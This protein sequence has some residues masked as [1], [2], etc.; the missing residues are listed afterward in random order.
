MGLISLPDKKVA[1]SILDEAY[2]LVT[3]QVTDDDGDTKEAV[4]RV[5]LETFLTN[6]GFDVDFDEDA[7]VLYLLDKTGQRV[8]VGTTIVAGITGLSMTT[9]EDDSGNQYLIL[10]D[11]NGVEL[12]RTE[13]NA[14]GS[15]TGSAYTCR[16]INGMTSANL[17]FPSGQSCTLT[18]EYYEYYGTERTTV[19]AT[20]QYYIRTG[21]SDYE[22]VK[23]ENIDQGTNSIDCTSYL[24]TG[25]NYFKIQVTGGES[26]TIKTLN[27]TLNVVDLS[28]TSTFSDSTAYSSAISFLYRV[29][30]KSLS[31]VM[32][33]YIDD[34]LYTSTDIGTSHNVQLTQTL[35][36]SSYGHG[37]HTLRCYFLT[38]DGTKSPELV[39]DIIYSTGE[40]DVIIGSTFDVDEVTYGET[41]TVEYVVYTY[42]SDYTDEITLGIY[43]LDADGEK[44][45]Y[46]QNTLENVVN[47]SVRTWSITDYP[48]S[49]TIY[50][51]L[52]SGETVR[53]FEVYVNAISGDRDLTDVSTRLIAAFSASGRSN[54]DSSKSY[55]SASYTSKDNIDTT[56]K[57]TLSNFNFR[58]NGWLTDD[59]GYPVLR[60]SG[61][62]EVDFNLPFL[63][64]SWTDDD[65]QKIQLA[66]SPTAAGRTFE[67]SFKTQKVTDEGAEIISI[68]DS[69]T[70]VGI[71]IFPSYAYMLSDSMSVTTDEDGNILNKN[72][73]PYVPY[74]STLDKVRLSFVIEQLGYYEESDGTQKQLLRIYVNGQL[75]SAVVYSSDSFTS[76]DALPHIAAESCILDVYSMRFYDYALDDAGVLKNYIYDLPSVSEKVEVY[77]ENAI[78]DDNDDIDFSLSV[79]QYSCM[80]ITGTLSAY[81]GDKTKVGVLLYKPDGSCDDGYYAE[82]DYMETDSDGNYGVQSNVQ[83]TSSQYYL[84]KNYKLTFYKLNSEGVF[85]KVKVYIFD[86]R[87]PVETIC[88]KA[89]YMS[90]DSANTGNANYWQTL[91]EEKTPP[92]ELDSSIQTSVMGYPILV[93]QRDTESDTPEFIGRYCLNN[94]K[95]NSNAFGLE[96]DSDSGNVT[97]CQKYEYLDNSEDICNWKTDKLQAERT[98]SDGNTYPAWQD[99]LESTYPD[100]GDLEDEGLEPDLDR[101]QMHY[102]WVVQ[103]ANFLDAST[104]SGTGGTYNDVEY[105]TEYALKLAIFK[106]EFSKHFNAHHTAHYFIAN[107]VPLLVDNLSK[108]FF[109]TIYT[110]NQQI[111]D[112]DGNEISVSDLIA[113]DGSG[114]VD[115]SNVDWVNST[116]D[117]IYPTLYDMDSCLGADN[118]GYDQFP[119]YAEMW[120]S[121]NSAM[122]VNGSSNLF[123]KLW[124]AAFYDDLKALYCQFRDTSGTLST[125][126]YLQALIDDLT[127]ALPIVAANRDQ[128]FKYID[129]YEGGYYTYETNEWLHTAAYM[130][131]VK[132]SMES[133]H[134]DFVTK[135]MAMLDSKYLEDSYINDNFNL[136]VNRGES[137]PED[138]AFSITPCQALYCY[139]EWGNS[140]TYIGGKCLEGESIEMK[141]ASSGNWSDIVLAMYGASHIKSFGDLSVLYPS[142]LQNL[143]LCTNLTDLILGSDA[144]GYS[145]SL[146]TA[147]PDVAYL[148]MLKKLNVCNLT[149]LSGTLDLSNCDLIEEVYATSSALSAVTFPEGGYMKIAKLPSGLTALTIIDHGEMEECTLESYS[150][151]LR[152]RVENTPNVPVEDIL[153]ERGTSLTRLRLV[154]VDWTLDDETLLEMLADDSWAGKAIDANGNAVDDDMTYP[155]ITGTVTVPSIRE[156]LLETLNTLYPNL[157][158]NYTEKYHIVQ[159]WADGVLLSEQTILDGQSATAPSVPS[160]DYT[161][162]YIYSF[163]GWDYSYSN[164]TTD[165]VCTA[166]WNAVLQAYNINFY[167]AEDDTETLGRV[168]G[169]YYGYAYQF[170]SDW[171]T[172]DGYIFTGWADE[173]GN[174]YEYIQ[175]FPDASAKI[176]SDGMPLEIDLYA[177]FSAVE[178]PSASKSLDQ[179][180]DGERLFCAIAIQ[181]G[182]ADGITVAYYKDSNEYILTDTSTLA[183]V[184][185]AV[186]DTR[187]FTAYNGETITQQV[188]DFNHDYTDEK[189]TQKAGITF[190]FQNCLTDARQ[191]NPS[192]KHCFN[193]QIGKDEAIVSDDDDHSS[194]TNDAA[195]ALLNHDHTATDEEVSAGYCDI[196]ALGPTYLAQ[197]VVTHADGTTTT[198]YFDMNGYYGSTDIESHS[199]CEFYL[200]D[201]DVDASNPFYKL[202]KM[203]E[204]AGEQIVGWSGTAY[205]AWGDT[206]HQWAYMTNERVEFS[207]FG[208]II[209]DTTGEDPYN[210]A[211]KNLYNGTGIPRIVFKADYTNNWNNFMEFSTGAVISVP[212]VE[213]DIVTVKAYGY[214][215]NWGGWGNT[216]LAEW[217]NSQESGDFLEQLPIGTFNTI[218][219]AYKKYNLGN[220]GYRIEGGLY[221][222]W[223]LSSAEVNGYKSYH[224]YMDEGTQY[225]IFTDND[226]R[227][228]YLAD[229]SGAVCT[230]WERSA[231]IGSTSYF[232]DVGASGNPYNSSNAYNRI[233]VVLGFC[234]GEV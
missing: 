105:D 150:G 67:I 205:T 166:K 180:T 75:A 119:Y 202:G 230:W 125:T 173:D 116:F 112:L 86:D 99:A 208:G 128:R 65:S 56:I 177:T 174:S 227:L 38:E 3:Q 131:L 12:C 95:S 207:D 209:F 154:G 70:G 2:V 83:G 4:R 153:T 102:S 121:Y 61:G 190:A 142:K 151:I 44:E 118:N 90:P 88:I 140:G 163:R 27:F 94:D 223:L 26:G 98:D 141:P 137:E 32:Y 194:A 81:K 104:E 201:T 146:L 53:T 66:G 204:A 101:M 42:G 167:A 68:W 165:V 69:N 139:T 51:E 127:A 24:S 160:R 188:L 182:A 226:S 183:V 149:A 100:Q 60:V 187:Q 6:I 206:Q 122:I 114:E 191:M 222:M 231:N 54:N 17:S 197:I 158:I 172:K 218:I 110:N 80:V 63:A 181:N 168:E 29:T 192:Y 189:E 97:V 157:T 79:Q 87:Q 91:L 134:R 198:W 1:S 34:E 14:T 74:S 47:Q 145:N 162:Q 161:V 164:V 7:Q 148:T 25:T 219:P 109:A 23:T 212:V 221:R 50:L 41:I 216:A 113:T 193:F 232:Y 13:F 143:S 5:P 111:L 18:Y 28:L 49:G 195:L 31:K 71:K 130:Y 10:L 220:C 234:S 175:V 229:G 45:Y 133:Y 132:S 82:Y 77:D 16:L 210:T 33:F 11:S 92:Q 58:S 233:G 19:A 72:V 156:T 169:V 40:S 129:A 179:L 62:A 155:T 48:S 178:F 21:T 89:D 138:L 170:P 30:G 124:Y 103:R 126:L 22:L 106:A 55:M 36:L 136:R 108:N 46:S 96:D 52:V 184:S 203:M 78:V 57:G 224:P 135:R 117:P 59:D 228:K 196:K 64:A 215:R 217:A 147:I 120:D 152:L 107:E 76:A 35:N 211:A 115:I 214:S 225:P 200:S 93:F 85:K 176:D 39:Y 20:A 144:E 9:E 43:T 123:W 15:G 8:G 37:H 185:I 171:P 213:G 73:I 159:F 84:K 199:L 186:G